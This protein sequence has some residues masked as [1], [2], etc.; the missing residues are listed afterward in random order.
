MKKILCKLKSALL[1]INE[2]LDEKN[3]LNKKS[4]NIIIFRPVEVDGVNDIA[5]IMCSSGTT[6][7]Y[8]GMHRVVNRMDSKF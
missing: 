7:T 6:G 4:R 5:A 8:K 3:D 2:Y 1:R